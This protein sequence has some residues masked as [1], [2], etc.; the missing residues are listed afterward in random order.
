MTWTTGASVVRW[1]DPH[2]IQSEVPGVMAG[3]DLWIHRK[4]RIHGLNQIVHSPQR[5]VLGIRD[6]SRSMKLLPPWL[7]VS[8][9]ASPRGKDYLLYGPC[10]A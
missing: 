9:F 6:Q 7:F 1:E 2:M 10:C 5:T 8:Q 3:P 4:S